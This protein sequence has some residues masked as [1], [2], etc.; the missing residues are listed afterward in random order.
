PVEHRARTSSRVDRRD[1][2]LGEIRHGV[3]GRSRLIAGLR[4]REDGDFDF[5]RQVA[6]ARLVCRIRGGEKPDRSS[7]SR[8]GRAWRTGLPQTL[9][10]PPAAG[11]S[12]TN[13]AFQVAGSALPLWTLASHG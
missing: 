1:A 12:E 3:E 8:T 6:H 7:A 2:R 11:R 5:E 4:L 13:L 9:A 10:R